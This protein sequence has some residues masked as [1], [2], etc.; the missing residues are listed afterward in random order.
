MLNHRSMMEARKMIIK[1]ITAVLLL[2][3]IVE[4]KTYTYTLY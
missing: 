3:H 1:Q 2:K 4:N